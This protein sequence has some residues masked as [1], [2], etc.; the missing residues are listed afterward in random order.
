[1]HHTQTINLFYRRTDLSQVQNLQNSPLYSSTLFNEVVGTAL[2]NVTLYEGYDEVNGLTIFDVEDSTF[3]LNKGALF[4]K[5]A[6]TNQSESN[7]LN[8]GVVESQILGG[9]GEY[10]NAKGTVTII[11]DEN[12]VRNVIIKVKH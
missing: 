1:M 6:L 4:F 3:F 2:Y 8:P 5:L 7:F 9:N 10:L 11:T 12:L